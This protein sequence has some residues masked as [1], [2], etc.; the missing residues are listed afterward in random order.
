MRRLLPE[1][2]RVEAED[3]YADLWDPPHAPD[4]PHVALGMVASVDGAASVDGRTD[5]LGGAADRVAFGALRE[6]CDAILVGATTVREE[7]YG[8]PLGDAARRQRRRRRGRSEVPRLAIVSG[9]LALDPRARVFAEAG[10]PPLIVTTGHAAAGAPE[11]LREV[12]EVVAVGA[13]RIDLHEAIALVAGRAGPR[14]LCEGGPSL[15]A[16]LLAVGLL[17][18]LFLTVTPVALAGTASRIIAGAG[19]TPTALELREMVEHE[20]ELLLRYGVTGGGAPSEPPERTTNGSLGSA[21]T[22]GRDAS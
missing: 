12:A 8:A 20:G 11:E 17:D 6:A 1:P 13:E 19:A 9:T 15:A 2:A 21:E 16:Q 18:E 14:L 4:R 5:R 3:L 7:D 22:H 10:H